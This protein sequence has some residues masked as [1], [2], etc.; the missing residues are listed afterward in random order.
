MFPPCRECM[1]IKKTGSWKMEKR[2]K[3]RIRPGGWA[4]LLLAL[5]CALLCSCQSAAEPEAPDAQEQAAPL[6][7][8]EPE[9]E[10]GK[11]RVSPSSC[12]RYPPMALTAS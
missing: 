10:P 9:P 7:E 11:K 3:L 1:E 12:G 2:T 5:L 6:P 4:V 8:P